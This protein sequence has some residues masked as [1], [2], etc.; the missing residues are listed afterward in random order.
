MKIR[1]K[2]NPFSLIDLARGG[3]VRRSLQERAAR[4]E[5]EKRFG[6][7]LGSFGDLLQDPRYQEVLK[8]SEA[9]LGEQ[10]TELVRHAKK[11]GQCAARSERVDLILQVIRRPAEMVYMDY[12]K[13]RIEPQPEVIRDAGV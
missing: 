3:F 13:V 4:K 11:C 9:V 1:Q 2:L 7:L 12:H 5:V 6:K 10:L 8:E